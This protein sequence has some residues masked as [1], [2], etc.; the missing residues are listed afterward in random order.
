MNDKFNIAFF[1]SSDFVAPILDSINTAQ[2]KTLVDIFESQVKYLTNQKVLSEWV[3]EGGLVDILKSIPRCNQPIKLSLVVTQPD[4]QNRG[5]TNLNPIA[6]YCETRDIKVYKPA[7]I[8]QSIENFKN[9]LNQEL[10]IGVVAS[11]GQIISKDIL[12]VPK[13]NFINWHP[14]YLPNYRGPTPIQTSILDGHTKTALTW[15]KISKKMDAGSIL[16]QLEK[17]IYPDDNFKDIAFAMGEIGA[18]TWILPVISRILIKELDKKTAKKQNSDEATFCKI[19]TKKDAVFDIN[20][21]NANQVYNHFRALISFPGTKFFDTYFNQT[22]KLTDC[23]L[24]E[25]CHKF[26]EDKNESNLNL[27]IQ[28]YFEMES[29]LNIQINGNWIVL[30]IQKTQKVFLTCN[31]LT[32]LEVKQITLE[33]GKQISFKGYQFK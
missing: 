24:D 32:I 19:L 2:D 17:E 12:D 27:K 11:F 7:D 14:S 25:S 22:I 28:K 30:K 26:N 4:T 29:D 18:N 3:N 23:S 16:L 1:G 21:F 20:K 8:N 15:I 10:D 5:K 33:N 13:Y 6:R 31:D 9:N